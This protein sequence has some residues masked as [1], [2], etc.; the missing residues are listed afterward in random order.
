MFCTLFY[1]C[2]QK[3]EALRFDSKRSSTEMGNSMKRYHKTGLAL[4][5]A[6]PGFGKRL[7]FQAAKNKKNPNP[8]CGVAGCQVPTKALPSLSFSAGQKRKGRAG[9]GHSPVTVRGQR[10]FTWGNHF[11]LLNQSRMVR[12]KR[13][14]SG[15]PSLPPTPSLFPG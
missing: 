11:N 15:T 2:W 14:V 5:Q 4:Q 6:S 7:V 12:N 9:R 1:F 10:D 3:V 13:Q 8:L